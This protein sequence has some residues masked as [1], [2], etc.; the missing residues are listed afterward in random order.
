[1]TAALGVFSRLGLPQA[2]G[3]VSGKGIKDRSPIP[4]LVN[5]GA[6]AVGAY[7]IKLAQ[8]ANIHPIIAVAGRGGDFVE[9]LIDRSK[10]DTIV[11]YREGEEKLVENIKK[12]LGGKKLHYAFDC[13]SEDGS[14]L[15][16]AKVLES[17]G[18]LTLVLPYNTYEGLPET[19]TQTF[20]NVA[21]AHDD[22]KDFAYVY[23]RYIARGLAEGWFKPH[24]S[25][26]IPGGLDGVKVAMERLRSGKASAVKY[27]L[28]IE[29]TPGVKKA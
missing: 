2:F 17:D 20:S 27:V 16:I 3:T 21:T 29:E 6:T 25:E 9:G 14:H 4:L 13:V 7:A 15:T 1:M 18:H 28:R 12:A 11:D 26:V 8:K 24:P 5:G 10:G 22:E 23:Y 19:V